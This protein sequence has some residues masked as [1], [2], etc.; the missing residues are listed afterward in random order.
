MRCLTLILLVGVLLGL[1]AGGVQ[2]STVVFYEN[3]DDGN[4]DA[5]NAKRAERELGNF[6]GIEQ[7]DYAKKV[8]GGEM[9]SGNYFS[10]LGVGARMG[11]TLLPEDDVSPGGHPVAV[12]GH[13]H[14]V[15]AFGGDE[16]VLGR[17]IRLAGRLYTIVGVAQEDY[18][19]YM[20]GLVPAFYVPILMINDI[21]GGNELEQRSNQ[22]SFVKARLKPG[23]TVEQARVSV[24]SVV[25][26]LRESHPSE[27]HAEADITLL[28]TQDVILW[29]PID[30][31]LRAAAWLLLAVVGFGRC[32]GSCRMS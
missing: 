10:A 26:S 1:A 11:R 32:Q 3:V 30:G 9:V 15:S 22:S 23:V 7:Y 25:S 18:H 20:R 12:L 2:A 8:A 6:K 16:N 29:P 24:A 27:W 21:N 4:G 19:G 14:W 28:P 13:G 5:A 17:Q 31:F